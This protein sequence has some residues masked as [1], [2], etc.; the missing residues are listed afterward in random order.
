MCGIA[1]LLDP[2]WG[3][4]DL[5]CLTRMTR[6]LTARGPDGEGFWVAPGVGLGHRR[7]SVID[8]TAAGTQPMGG[9][10][11]SVQVTF[12]GEIY[13][14]AGLADELAGRGHR[15]HSRCDTD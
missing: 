9:E 2:T 10:D 6:A 15:F 3:D 8:L 12:N 11:A 13:N 7:L 5:G 4:I 14:F 1:G